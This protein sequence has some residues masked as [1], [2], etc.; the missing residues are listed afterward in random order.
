MYILEDI[1]P[2]ITSRYRSYLENQHQISTVTH[3]AEPMLNAGYINVGRSAIGMIAA[4]MVAAGLPSPK[5]VLD[6]ACGYGR[7]ARYLKV[8]FRT[9]RSCAAICIP[10]WSSFA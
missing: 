5:R 7:V 9:A 2:Q 6:L 10:K 8:F 4:S 1:F 3:P